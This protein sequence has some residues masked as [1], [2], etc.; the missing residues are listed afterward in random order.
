MTDSKRIQTSTCLPCKSKLTFCFSFYDFPMGYI[1]PQ[2][3]SKTLSL[4]AAAHLCHSRWWLVV[5]LLFATHFHCPTPA[6]VDAHCRESSM[7]LSPAAFAANCQMLPSGTLVASHRLSLTLL[8]MVAASS[9]EQRQQQT[10]HQ[11][12]RQSDCVWGCSVSV[13]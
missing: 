7:L 2:H 9:A 6:F 1:S 10:H 8:T 12:H 13:K 4:P 11:H 3:G 5:A